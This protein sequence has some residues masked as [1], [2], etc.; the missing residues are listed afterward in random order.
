MSVSC[1]SSRVTV[2]RLGGE[3]IDQSREPTGPH[4]R[5]LEDRGP[6][7][8]LQRSDPDPD[9]PAHHPTQPQPVEICKLLVHFVITCREPSPWR[10]AHHAGS[11]TDFSTSRPGSQPL[12]DSNGAVAEVDDRR[13]HHGQQDRLRLAQHPVDARRTGTVGLGNTADTHSF[14]ACGAN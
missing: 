9:I 6:T 8:R 11:I 3:R 1:A 10:P 12:F 5:I 2:L 4:P 14:E 7:R 13:L